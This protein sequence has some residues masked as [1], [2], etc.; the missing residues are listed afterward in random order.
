MRE[1]CQDSESNEARAQRFCWGCNEN[2]APPNAEMLR[3][4]HDS[5]S[6][7]DICLTHAE[8]REVVSGNCLC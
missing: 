4:V 1:L 8:R 3:T 5:L 7:L 2:Q 6:V